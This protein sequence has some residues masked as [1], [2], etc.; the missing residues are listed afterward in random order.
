MIVTSFGNISNNFCAKKDTNIKKQNSLCT[1]KDINKSKETVQNFYEN[2]NKSKV[3]IS[4]NAMWNLVGIITPAQIKPTKAD[5]IKAKAFEERNRIWHLRHNAETNLTDDASVKFDFAKKVKKSSEKIEKESKKYLA[6]A[7]NLYKRLG[8]IVTA[9]AKYGFSQI[10][11][12]NGNKVIFNDDNNELKIYN[13]QGM[14]I[15]GAKFSTIEPSFDGKNNN[16]KGLVI[17]SEI[18]KIDND[19]LYKYLFENGD[20][21]Y[22]GK[23]N[24]KE[25]KNRFE[26]IYMYDYGELTR[27]STMYKEISDN[28]YV[29]KD[30]YDFE[31]QKLKCFSEINLKY[32]GMNSQKNYI[33]FNEKNPVSITGKKVS[34]EYNSDTI[35]KNTYNYD[36]EKL[37]SHVETHKTDKNGNKEENGTTTFN[38]GKFHSYCTSKKTGN[39]KNI[40]Y[41]YSEITSK[42]EFKYADKAIFENDGKETFYNAITFEN[43]ELKMANKKNVNNLNDKNSIYTDTYGFKDNMEKFHKSKI[44]IDSIIEEEFEK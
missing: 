39:G 28:E 36:N 38:N 40:I 2:D 25:T 10:V 35:F 4:K 37:T 32:N 44:A 42:K 18:T 11:L 3:D 30:V 27:Y 22:F 12:F 20:L 1:E 23:T 8:N 9:G 34:Y 19:D 43:G 7:E 33:E 14:P 41:G 21:A 13:K 6:E 31:N 5:N 17:F 24:K 16:Q 15:F 26:N 29:A